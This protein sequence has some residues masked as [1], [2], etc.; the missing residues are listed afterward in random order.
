M[1]GTTDSTSY[2]RFDFKRY[3]EEAL[4]LTEA[5]KKASETRKSDPGYIYRVVPADADSTTFYVDRLTASEVSAELVSK[6]MSLSAKLL[7]R[8]W[9]MR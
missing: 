8:M 4:V 7:S 9:S 6:L 2:D 1:V 3:D 5:V